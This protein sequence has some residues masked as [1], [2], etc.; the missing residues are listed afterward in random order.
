MEV[1]ALSIVCNYDN[2]EPEAL[3]DYDYN[4]NSTPAMLLRGYKYACLLHD[5]D[6]LA[7]LTVLPEAVV[8]ICILAIPLL[9]V[10]SRAQA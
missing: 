6:M 7:C 10:S 4:N 9:R 1:E 8:P 3:P 2:G 5:T